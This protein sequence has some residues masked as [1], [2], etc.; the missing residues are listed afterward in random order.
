MNTK[1]DNDLKNLRKEVFSIKDRV[2]INCGQEIKKEM[3][4][5]RRTGEWLCSKCYHKKYDN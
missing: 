4:L 5:D 3:I 1:I 2:C